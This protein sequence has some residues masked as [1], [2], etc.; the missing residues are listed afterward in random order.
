VPDKNQTGKDTAAMAN[1]LS[2]GFS[3][4]EN[5]HSATLSYLAGM[6]RYTTDFFIPYVLSTNYFQRVEGVR[7]LKEPPMDSFEAYLNLLDNNMELINRSLNGASQMMMAYTQLLSND[8]SEAW[9]QSFI[10]QKH[11]KIV[12][13]TKR[14]AELLNQVIHAY[15]KAI[16]AIEPEFGF[17]FERGEHVLLDETDRFLLYRVAPSIKGMETRTDAKPLLILPPYVLGANILAFLPGEQRSYAHCFANQG[18]PTYIRVL[19][20]IDSSPALQVMTGEDDAKDTRR[21]CES[22]I[23]A[24]GKPVTLNGYCQGGFS[25]LCNLLSGELDG[26]V[27]AFITCVSPMDGTRSKGLS[28]FLKRLPQR[29]N[30][31]AYGTKILPNGNH[32]ADGQLMGWVYKLKSIEQEIPAAAFFRD[33]MM[34]ARQTNGTHKISKTALGLNY[35]LQNERFDLP[36]EITRMSFASYNDPITDDGTLPVRLFGNKLNLKRLKEKKIPWLICY[37]THDDLVERE[38]ALAPLDHVD[39]EVTPFPK[40]HVAIAT[41]WSSPDT[42]CALHTRFGDGDYRGPV[43]FHMD[44]EEALPKKACTRT[45][46]GL[47]TRSDQAN[48]Q[49]KKAAAKKAPAVRKTI[50]KT[51][52]TGSVKI[53]NSVTTKQKNR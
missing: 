14:Q 9:R 17:H 20:E 52:P 8:I 23:K 10:E 32:V 22:I 27:D 1:A 4:L 11:E 3:V 5:L 6:S 29:F 2:D 51:E 21:F 24:H 34:F 28:Y 46:K 31:L 7:L 16:D 47:E 38:T 26:L 43:R 25:G 40:G 41:S 50:P 53:A 15:P 30:D 36:L 49:I 19:K 13:Y 39:A 18:F 44:L 45:A 48:S 37:G 35:W 42:A 12:H 33:L